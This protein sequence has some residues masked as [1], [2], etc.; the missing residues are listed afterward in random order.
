MISRGENEAADALVDKIT[1]LA[2]SLEAESVLRALGEWHAL[3]GRWTSA[4]ERFSLLQ[5]VDQK[6]N[7][8]AITTDLLMAGPIQIERG[9]MQG[10]EHFRQAAIIRYTG[11]TDPVFAERTLKISLLVPADDKTMH[12]LRAFSSL[13]SDSLQKPGHDPLMESWRCV[14]LGLMAYRQ[15]YTP[16]AKVWCNQCLSYDQNNSAR[17]ATAH[18]IQ[19]MACYQL[20]ETEMATNELVLGRSQIEAKFSKDLDAGD[21]LNGFWYDWL[22]A[23]ILQQEAEGLIEKSRP[24]KQ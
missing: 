1:R 20:G 2:P 9:D 23:R 21:G 24:A 6:D 11:T 7:S 14:S 22:F 19:A 5:D 15:G 8:W 17:I 16:T 13:A 4:A 10:Y 12:V 18:V 3:K